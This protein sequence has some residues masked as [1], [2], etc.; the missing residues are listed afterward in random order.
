MNRTGDNWDAGGSRASRGTFCLTSCEIS[1]LRS[2]SRVDAGG[3]ECG[4]R[5]VLEGLLTDVFNRYPM[6][7]YMVLCYVQR[8]NQMQAIL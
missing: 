4:V 7:T 5:R 3:K 1:G 8:A 6:Y 2:F